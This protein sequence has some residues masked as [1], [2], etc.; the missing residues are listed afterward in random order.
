MIHPDNDDITAGFMEMGHRMP[1]LLRQ[2]CLADAQA[3]GV[4]VTEL[5]DGRWDLFDPVTGGRWRCLDV[6]ALAQLLRDRPWA[7]EQ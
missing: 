6:A 7:D 1:G 4:E 5:D 3:A 2:R